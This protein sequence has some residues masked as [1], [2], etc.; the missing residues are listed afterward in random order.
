MKKT[1]PFSKLFYDVFKYLSH[2]SPIMES[3]K[4]PKK[5]VKVMN[6]NDFDNNRQNNEYEIYTKRYTPGENGYTEQ[7]NFYQNGEYNSNSQHKKKGT[8]LLAVIAVV[9]CAS[10]FCAGLMLC[11]AMVV[12]NYFDNELD[13]ITVVERLPE[14][15]AA[16]EQTETP[17]SDKQGDWFFGLDDNSELTVSDSFEKES[18]NGKIGDE[19]LSMADVVELVSA[20]VVEITTSETLKNGL[21]YSS[22]AGSGVIVTDNGIIITNNHVVEGATEISVRLSNGNV[23]DAALVATDADTDLAII[24][25]EP[26]EPLTIAVGGNSDNIRVGEEVIAIGNPLGLLGGTVTN[27]IVSALEREVTIGGETMTLL[28]HNAA[29]SPGNSGG[30]L[31]NMRGELI[32]IVNA[33]YSSSGAEGLGF[34][35]P[36]NTV[37]AVY[38]DLVNY[39]YVK[40]KAD[41]G[42]S[43]IQQYVMRPGYYGY[44]LYIVE[45]KYSD[46]LVYGDRLLAVDGVTPA[47]TDEAYSLLERYKI[48]DKVAITVYRSGQEKTVELTVSEYRP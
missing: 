41:H 18:V 43:I 46:E 38:H 2:S 45:S 7:K 31:F 24:K 35:I 37:K 11:T 44:A 1:A 12:S 48:G 22:G 33:K 39:G 3:A 20:S 28:Q 36:M 47:T 29:V 14:G 10:V 6:N 30:A 40:G 25:I 21:V 16:P 4:S 23:Y 34:A 9:L 32:G 8:R 26:K 17:E 15:S 5:G 19:N 13:K 27:G 42:L